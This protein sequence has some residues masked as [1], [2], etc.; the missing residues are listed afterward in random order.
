MPK[1]DTILSLNY[2]KQIICATSRLLTSLFQ[3]ASNKANRLRRKVF[4]FCHSA[5][6][7]QRFQPRASQLEVPP[8]L[9]KEFPRAW[10][11]A[12]N[13]TLQ[14]RSNNMGCRE[15][16]G[17]LITGDDGVARIK[18]WLAVETPR[19]HGG[20]FVPLKYARVSRRGESEAGWIRG[21]EDLAKCTATCRLS[22]S[23]R[24][25]RISSLLRAL[26]SSIRFA[27]GGARHSRRKWEPSSPLRLFIAGFDCRI[28]LRY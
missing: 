4:E 13:R 27:S 10:N 20:A 8:R 17:S 5:L 6:A 16:A 12:N 7:R 28:C 25:S 24:L 3:T 18:G 19:V 9:R 21:A 14:T 15:R 26:S 1:Y 11:E 2:R 23:R 22:I